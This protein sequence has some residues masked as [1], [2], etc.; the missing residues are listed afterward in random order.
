MKKLDA[1]TNASASSRYAQYVVGKHMTARPFWGE[2]KE[3]W[4][5]EIG[6]SG[7]PWYAKITPS[8]GSILKQHLRAICLDRRRIYEEGH[9]DYQA[10]KERIFKMRVKAIEDLGG[11]VLNATPKGQF[12]RG[13]FFIDDVVLMVRAGGINNDPELNITKVTSS[14]GHSSRTEVTKK[15]LAAIRAS[16]DQSD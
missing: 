7:E 11:E 12:V 15:V 8:Y 16:Y 13:A 10:D 6:T 14:K 1:Y 5:I 4:G 3:D 9:E 2:N